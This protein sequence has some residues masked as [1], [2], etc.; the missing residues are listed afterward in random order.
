MKRWMK[1]KADI[2]FKVHKIQRKI[3]KNSQVVQPT[4]NASFLQIKITSHKHIL[5]RLMLDFMFFWLRFD[6]ETETWFHLR[7]ACCAVCVMLPSCEFLRVFLHC[8]LE[9]R[10]IFSSSILSTDSRRRFLSFSC[11]KKIVKVKRKRKWNLKSPDDEEY[12]KCPI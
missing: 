9:F 6:W 11:N 2:I 10:R 12:Q 3:V 5:S 7:F 4:G 8:L 1:V